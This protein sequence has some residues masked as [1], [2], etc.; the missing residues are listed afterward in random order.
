VYISQL[1][2]LEVMLINGSDVLVLGGVCTA[3]R[4]CHVISVDMLESIYFAYYHS[5]SKYGVLFLEGGAE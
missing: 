4:V 5:V 2:K 3:V 1:Y